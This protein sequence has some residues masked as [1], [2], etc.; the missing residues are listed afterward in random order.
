MNA[1]SSSV[2]STALRQGFICRG[3]S[4]MEPAASSAEELVPALTSTQLCMRWCQLGSLK[5]AVMELFTPQKLANAAGQVHSH[6]TPSLPESPLLESPDTTAWGQL[7][8]R[9]HLSQKYK[10]RLCYKLSRKRSVQIGL[11]SVSSKSNKV[12][13]DSS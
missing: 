5:S 11:S 2:Q 10:R 7:L 6:H 9:N 13:N 3:A 12:L 4:G 8:G 1:I